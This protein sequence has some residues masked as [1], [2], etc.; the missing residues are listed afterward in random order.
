MISSV[1][2]PNSSR[3]FTGINSCASTIL[4]QYWKSNIPTNKSTKAVITE[5]VEFL[6]DITINVIIA[7]YANIISVPLMNIQRIVVAGKINP[8][9]IGI[10]IIK[11]KNIYN[12][13]HAIDNIIVVK[14]LDI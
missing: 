12:T 2:L 4:L 3:T 9:N 10:V 8:P 6:L 14:R 11:K 7:E 13:L 1:I 5:A